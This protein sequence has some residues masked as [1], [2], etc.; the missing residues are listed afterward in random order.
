LLDEAESVEERI[1]RFLDKVPEEAVSGPGTRIS[2]ASYLLM[3]LDLARYPFY[4]PTPFEKVERVL[5]WPRALEEESPGAVYAHHR[6]F[7][8]RLLEELQQDGADARDL[9]DVQSLIWTLANSGEPAVMIWRGE[10]ADWTQ[11]L[12]PVLSWVQK[13]NT[14]GSPDGSFYY[15]PLLLL[16]ALDVL[17]ADPNPRNRLEYDHLLETFNDLPPNVVRLLLRSSSRSLTCE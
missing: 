2:I 1:D 8:Q 9:L 6:A 7:A 3:G 10:E 16:A 4:K 17:D 15:K 12:N 11:L 14:R 13:L 5:G